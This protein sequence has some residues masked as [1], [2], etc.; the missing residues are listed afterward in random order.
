MRA[1]LVK[2]RDLGRLMGN[3]NEVLRHYHPRMT[4][5]VCLLLI[6]PVIGAV[7]LANAGH[8]PPFS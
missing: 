3:L 1:F 7:E 6:D 5:T 4:A 2:E 8:I